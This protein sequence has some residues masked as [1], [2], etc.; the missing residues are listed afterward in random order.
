MI[1]SPLWHD[2]CFIDR[3]ASC[4]LEINVMIAFLAEGT[5]GQNQ[6]IKKYTFA[7]ALGLIAREKQS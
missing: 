4:L 7:L 2:P 3:K 5:P 6:I 1:R